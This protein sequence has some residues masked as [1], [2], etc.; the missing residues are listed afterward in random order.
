M[1]IGCLI[2]YIVKVKPMS[3]D[4]DLKA[5]KDTAFREEL[6]FQL[7]LHPDRDRGLIERQV[8]NKIYGP[9]KMNKGGEVMNDQEFKVQEI[10]TPKI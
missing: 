3:I 8:R 9:K 10:P 5:L 6:E 4:D 1:S 7:K 2:T